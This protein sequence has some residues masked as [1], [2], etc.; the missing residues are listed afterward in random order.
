MLLT[1]P[2]PERLRHTFEEVLGLIVNGAKG[3]R[4]DTGLD[5][6]TCEVLY[7]LAAQPNPKRDADI[8][9]CRMEFAKQLDGTHEREGWNV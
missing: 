7:A 8:A 9:A 6:Q 4:S 3:F 5:D 2:T 1:P